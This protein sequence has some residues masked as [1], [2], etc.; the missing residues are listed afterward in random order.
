MMMP[1]INENI[2]AIVDMVV[3]KRSPEMI[4]LFGSYAR[5]ED[6]WDSDLDLLVVTETSLTPLARVMDIRRLFEPAPCP[7]DVLVYTPSEVAYW[8]ESPSSFISQIL[9]EGHI[10]YDRT[11]KK[12]GQTVG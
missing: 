12:V 6:Q 4:V 8:R 2:R 3:E 7:L 5:Q 1:I 11:T 10:L 9:S